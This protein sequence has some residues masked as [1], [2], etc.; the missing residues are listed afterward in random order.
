MSGALESLKV[1]DFTTLLP[2]PFATMC[3][4]DMGADVLR[5]TSGSRPDLVEFL[6]P[7]LAATGVGAVSAYLGRGKRSLA[8]NLKDPRGI[9]IVH[10][11]LADYDIVIEQFRPGIM[12][13]LGLDYERLKKVNPRV[14]YCSI[15]GYG[16]MGPLRDRAGHDMNYM[17]LSGAMG[18]SGRK[19]TGPTL[20]GIQI[21]DI[22]SGSNNAVIGILAAV[23]SRAATGEGQYIDISMTDGVMA[24]NAM[25]GAAYLAG[26]EAPGR[27]ENW[28]NGGSLYDFYATKDGGYLS[29]GSLEPQFFRTLCEVIGRPDLIPGGVQPKAGDFERVREEIRAIVRTKTR[30]EW[31]AIFKEVDACVEPVLSLAEALEGELAR[32]R[33]MVV[34]VPLAAPDG[35][36]VGRGDAG[37]GGGALGAGDGAF[38]AGVQGAGKAST[39]KESGARGTAG[40][41]GGGGASG[42]AAGDPGAATGGIAAPRATVRQLANPV[43]FS[44]TPASYAFAGVKTGTHNREVLKALGYT[45]AQIAEFAATGLFD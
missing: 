3:L 27:E 31:E 2:G 24:L 44:R 7:R 16:Q 45:E 33:E 28:L 17:A 10:R 9:E 42:K 25:A 29:I 15:S 43:K 41:A 36:D 22:A 5:V 6:S 12:T 19:A 8:L 13:K 21:A 30:A 26:G 4:A 11:L 35:S 20:M 1:L 32:G 23:V 39:I 40:A 14:I 37:G 34:D 18:Y 38:A